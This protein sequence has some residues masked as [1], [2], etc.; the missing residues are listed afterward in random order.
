MVTEILKIIKELLEKHT[1][2]ELYALRDSDFFYILINSS[3]ISIDNQLGHL[4]I[5]SYSAER[6]R[7]TNNIVHVFYIDKNCDNIMIGHNEKYSNLNSNADECFIANLKYD[8]IDIL[9]DISKLI[10]R[11]II[12]SFEYFGSELLEAL[13][14]I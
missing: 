8:F 11:N 5:I 2:D 12:L 4:N 9:L 3:R 1:L 10:D 7:Y 6:N 13:P 14:R